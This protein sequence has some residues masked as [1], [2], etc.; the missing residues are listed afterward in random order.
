MPERSVHVLSDASCASLL[1]LGR[2]AKFGGRHRSGLNAEDPKDVVAGAYDAIA[3][4]YA[5]WAAS[6]KSPVVSWARRFAEHVA[7]GGR[8]L[9]LPV[10]RRQPGDPLLVGATTH[11]G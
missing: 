7:P 2:S 10:R 6:F 11:G 1:P 4:Q 3:D 5:A 9:E 8:V